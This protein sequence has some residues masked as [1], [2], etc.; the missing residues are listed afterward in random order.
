MA[1][2]PFDYAERFE[3]QARATPSTV[4]PVDAEI[5][6]IRAEQIRRDV[7]QAPNPDDLAKRDRLAREAGVEPYQIDDTGGVERSLQTRDFARMAERYPAIGKFA[8]SNPRN[9]AL[10]QDDSESLGLIGAAW[11]FLSNAPGRVFDTGGRQTAKMAASSYVSAED[12]YSAITTAPLRL[13]SAITGYESKALKAADDWRFRDRQTRLEKLDKSA[14]RSRDRFGSEN[15]VVEAMLS[16]AESVPLTLLAAA[17][18]GAGGGAALIGG[19]VGADSLQEGRSK[20]LRGAEALGYGFAQG[21]AEGA[22][23]LIPMGELLQVG[24]RGFVRGFGRYMLAETP[25]EMATTVVQS[26]TDWA[27]LP[28]NE[29]KTMQDWVGGL[30]GELQQTVLGVLGG[31]TITVSTMYGASRLGERAERLVNRAREADQAETD[32]AFVDRIADGK[33]SSKLFMRDPEAF[34]DMMRQAAGQ[35]GASNVFVPAEAVRAFQQS[36]RYDP[37]TDPFADENYQ[38]ALNSGGDI[39]VP[40]EDYLTDV[41]GTKAFDAISE[42]VRLT[43]G[44]MSPREAAEFNEGIDQSLANLSRE[45]EAPGDDGDGEVRAGLVDQLALQFGQ[46]FTSPVARQIAELA[47]TRA[48]TRAE[49][50]G[51]S[52][53]GR[54]FDDLRVRQ[55]L[56]E[57]VAEAVRAD[58]IDLLI[59]AMREGGSPEIGIGNSLLQFIQERGGIND[60]GGDLASIG[61]PSRLIRDFDPD[62]GSFDG[63]S[64]AGQFGLDSTLRAAIE[65]GFFSDLALVENETGP[66][67]LDTQVLLDAIAEELAGNPVF[68]ETRTDP[69]REGAEQLREA[70][71]QSGFDPDA[72]SDADIRAAIDQME[73]AGDG[74]VFNQS[75][76]GRIIFDQSQ[77]IIELF[78]SR[79]LSTPLH[80]LGHMWLEELAADASLPG[81]PQQIKNDFE[82]VKAWFK[83]NGHAVGQDGIIPTDAHEMWAR[84]TERYLMEGKGPSEGLKRLFDTFRSWLLGI[85]R[86]V[87]RL[88]APITPEIREVMDRMLATDEQIEAA[89][90][91]QALQELFTDAA[92]VG[93]SE[94]EFEA[95]RKQLAD[96]RSEAVGNLTEKTLRSA[97]HKVKGEYSKARK[98]IRSE[99]TERIDNSPLYR[100]INLMR[101]SRISKEWIE[102][103][104]GVD[105]LKLLP[106]RV[107]P[108]YTE[109]GTDP[110]IIAEVT[111]YSGAREMIKALMGAE[112]AH[113]QA[114]EGGDKRSMRERAIQSATDAEFNRR[115]GDPMTDGSIEREALASVN[116][117]KQGEVMAAELRVLSRRTGQRPTPYR[118]ARQWARGKVRAG[119]VKD[120]A[121][122]AALQRY[123]RN[124][125]RASRAAQQAMLDQNVDEAFRQKQFQM[126]NSALLAEANEA[127]EDV[128][129]AVKRMDKIARTRTRKSVDQD[130]LEQA[131]ALL[132]SVELRKRSQVGIDRAGQFEA[133]AAAQEAEGSEVLT[134]RSFEAIL[135]RTNYTRL[136]VENILLLDEQ[137]KQIIHLG[138]LKQ[139][140]IDNKE[141]R[142]FGEVVAEAEAA[143]DNI[144]RKPPQGSF[145]DPSWW[146]STKQKVS[147]FDAGL[148]RM[149]QVFDWLDQ[150]NSNGV[151]NRVVFQPISEAQARQREM[152]E[153]Y[154]GKL[155][156]AADRVPDKTLRSWVDRVTVDLID[157]ETGLPAVM[158]RKRLIA[159][160]LNWGNSGNRQRLADGYGWNENGI[161]AA[162]L[163][164]LAAEEWQYVQDVWDALEGL[165]PSIAQMERAVNG[166]EPDKVDALPIE[167]PF[168]KLRGGYYPAVYD[169]T[170][171]YDAEERQ[172]AKSDLFSSNYIRATTRSSATKDRAERVSRPILLDLGVINRHLGEVIHDVTHRE[173]VMNAHKFLNDRRV[174]RMIDETL[175]REI[176]QQMQPWLN[177]IANSWAS[178]RAGNEGI[179][180]FM[181]KLRANTT[182]VGMGW[183]FTTIMTQIAGYSNSF[184]QVGA[185][186]VAPEIAKFQAQM[187]GSA[188][189]LVM[190]QGVQMPEMM[191]FALERSDELKFRLDTLD[192]D[193]RTEMDRLN[194]RGPGKAAEGLTAMK[195]FAFHGIGYMDRMVSVPT[196]MGAYNKALSEGLNEKDAAFAADKAIRLS[197]GAG[198]PKDLASVSRGTG[199]WGEAFKLLTMFYTYLSSVYSRQRN[200]GRDVRRAELKDLP[201]L[202]ARAWWLIVVPPLL[203]EVLSGRGPEED[204]EWGWWAFQ[205]ML[206]Q[207]LGAIPI[208]RDLTDPVFDR[209]QGQQGFDYRLTPLQG[210]GQS[211]VNVAG[212]ASKI[213]QG[214]ETKRATRNALEAVGYTTGMVPG[215]IAASSQFLVDVSRGDARPESLEDWYTGLTKGRLPDD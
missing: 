176:R 7:E 136:S 94:Q 168:G 213:A 145:T 175:G 12:A 76:H 18:G 152:M 62:R 34:R 91:T 190:L 63:L 164:N 192:R 96:A 159:M 110:N 92:Q 126:L 206:S 20:G 46:S 72:M 191:A 204:E 64:G 43:A 15:Y 40:I 60:V 97:R 207:S 78:Q 172:A 85:Y 198:A 42:D 215:Q 55:V 26:F 212:D 108:L 118:I 165:W 23:E 193:I 177:Y 184:E 31:G 65:E 183:R 59:N 2:N 89:R 142:E 24:G 98:A 151:F 140:L 149:E 208:V 83:S 127:L 170:L 32:A 19:V 120:E 116:N 71:V 87:M 88:N 52:L 195:R 128:A 38:D 33:K 49:R 146:E 99:E 188:G 61:L 41:V 95:Y 117:E 133:W 56:P 45:F 167:T 210:V 90:E 81:A 93:M 129:K 79:N 14:Q 109:R 196:W 131:Q 171:D 160:A 6:R 173:P 178:E 36:D 156:E 119:L 174:K 211:V 154:H 82:T 179:G 134:P 100:A 124:A 163:D 35:V 197:Q 47:V 17:T 51:Q 155:K 122:P 58:E 69:F 70:L 143:G 158:E 111:G 9:A 102:D 166:V 101:E 39:V 53:N 25:S 187:A 144:G 205:K 5:E 74:R 162:L 11:E 68:S 44:G 148:L 112:R 203:A 182:V 3:R 37:A 54:E 50:L 157:P 199:R 73:E 202:M 4:D 114:K 121:M 161:Q 1:T 30:P 135:G 189:R 115:Y 16:G 214:K 147:A 194:A 29:D 185:R 84:G 13:F 113:R 27:I 153:E 138:R 66:S 181:G 21:A 186:W 139:T 169:S 57:G 125:E 67:T 150:G 22:F 103:N 86:D 10:A 201:N 107:P 28:E 105:A 80:E 75:A 48:E 123:R 180:R 130:Y 200:L 209:L 106:R 8:S 137:V 77:R 141:Q 132:E 104:M